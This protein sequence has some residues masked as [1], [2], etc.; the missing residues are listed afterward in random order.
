MK[1]VDEGLHEVL[2][3]HLLC[4]SKISL[5]IGLMTG[6]TLIFIAVFWGIS[7]VKEV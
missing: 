2:K 4:Y 7:K 1:A 3:M 5:L 6:L